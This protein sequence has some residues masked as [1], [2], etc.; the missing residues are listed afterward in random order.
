[1]PQTSKP[2]NVYSG[3]SPND[4]GLQIVPE[5][6]G[7]ILM[8]MA[9]QAKSGREIPMRC[10][11][12]WAAGYRHAPRR[13]HSHGKVDIPMFLFGG[14]YPLAVKAKAEGP[15]WIP[16]FGADI[17]PKCGPPAGSHPGSRSSRVRGSST[18]PHLP[19]H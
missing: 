15:F 8:R 19:V 4:V 13:A 1:M 2:Q 6:L 17:H 3:L 5:A 9:I 16:R 10:G 14:T 11:T 12:V 7:R 18:L